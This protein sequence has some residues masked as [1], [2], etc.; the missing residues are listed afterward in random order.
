MRPEEQLRAA[1]RRV[2]QRALSLRS[3][4]V[5]D[6]LRFAFQLQLN[7]STDEFHIATVLKPDFNRALEVEWN[8]DHLERPAP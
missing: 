5:L 6:V 8:W 3:R 1:I 7:V 4:H 2:K